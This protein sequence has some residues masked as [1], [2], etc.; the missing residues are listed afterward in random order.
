GNQALPRGQYEIFAVEGEQQ[1]QP[2][3]DLLASAQPASLSKTP[4]ASLPK[5]F[6]L[7]ASRSYFL[8]GTQDATYAE[9]LKEFHDKLREKAAKELSE[10]KQFEATL[11]ATLNTTISDFGIISKV[12]GQAA[13]R[14]RWEEHRKR[15]LGFSAQ[16]TDIFQKWTPQVLETEFFYGSL[17]TMIQQVYR[18]VEQLHA[19][20]HS[21]F[22]TTV[23][24]KA[25]EIQAGQATATATAGM[26][27]LKA[28]IEQ[29]EK[30]PPAPNG[31]PRREGL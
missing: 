9:R 16:M 6:K 29:A 27:A 24:P 31:M 13:R 20:H 18:G 22:T 12:K 26:A 14:K 11:N 23:D 4:P 10:I 8:G 28:K 15:W 25:F 7:I 21:Y 1:P 5:G 2:I 30:I 3:K 19:V 17:Y